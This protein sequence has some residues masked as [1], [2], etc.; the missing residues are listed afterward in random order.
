VQLWSPHRSED[1]EGLEK[2]QRGATKLVLELRKLEYNERLKRLGLTT[3][4]RR[5][6]RGDLIE[7]YKILSRKE[8]IGSIQFFPLNTNEHGLRAHSMKVYK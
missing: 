8:R 3:L 7:T 1:I 2:V 5:R 4:Q 6:T